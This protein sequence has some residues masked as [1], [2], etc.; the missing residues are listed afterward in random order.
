MTRA[1]D[2]LG[3]GRGGD[4]HRP[5]REAEL[6]LDRRVAGRDQAVL[7]AGRGARGD[8]EGVGARDAELGDLAG[9]VEG[10]ADVEAVRRV[11]AGRGQVLAHPGPH[12][13]L[14]VLVHADL[15]RV[16]GRQAPEQA[17]DQEHD[18]AVGVVVGVAERQFDVLVP[19]LR[20]VPHLAVVQQVLLQL[21]EAGPQVADLDADRVAVQRGLLLGRRSPVPASV[22]AAVVPARPTGRRG[23]RAIDEDQLDVRGVQGVGDGLVLGRELGDR[24]DDAERRPVRREAVDLGR[25]GL[26]RHR[27]RQF[28]SSVSSGARSSH[29]SR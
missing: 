15:M 21:G 10:A 20:P 16:A 22:S 9:G 17:A 11:G 7:P 18:L 24:R 29:I 28:R 23:R 3:P 8:L 2:G 6:R 13:A 14:A 1:L 4:R 12:V 27:E 26:E 25:E 5:C 19:P